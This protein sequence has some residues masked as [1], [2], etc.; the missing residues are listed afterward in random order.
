MK[1][2]HPW[3]S[4]D[5]CMA[6]HEVATKLKAVDPGKPINASPVPHPTALLSDCLSCHGVGGVKPAAADDHQWSNNDTCMACHKQGTWNPNLVTSS[7]TGPTIPH[8]LPGG[9][10]CSSC[11]RS[12]GLAPI[13]DSHVGLSDSLCQVCHKQGY[14]PRPPHLLRL[15]RDRRYHISYR[16]ERPVALRATIPKGRD[17]SRLHT[18]G[19]RITCVWCVISRRPLSSR[20]RQR[21]AVWAQQPPVPLR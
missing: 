2:T 18:R 15:L 19:S 7:P 1:V 16:P 13:P 20:L 5:T 14:G 12:G 4:N 6:C 17:R 11:H 8:L 9:F 10:A 21:Q 3:A